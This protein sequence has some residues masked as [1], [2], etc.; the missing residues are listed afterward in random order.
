MDWA[1]KCKGRT[2]IVV[3]LQIQEQLCDRRKRKRGAN[4]G[5]GVC[6]KVKIVW[7]WGE[8]LSFEPSPRDGAFV[9][10]IPSGRD[11]L[12]KLECWV[13]RVL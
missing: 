1:H 4:W 2:T 9:A 3:I 8:I 12:D 7:W 6:G 13:S 5:C 10:S 11:A